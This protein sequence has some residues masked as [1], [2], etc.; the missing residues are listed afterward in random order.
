MFSEIKKQCILFIDFKQAFDNINRNSLVEQMQQMKIPE[1]LIKLT[2]MTMGNS[3]ARISTAEGVT[4]EI[5]IK[6]G[7]RQGDALSSTLINIALDGAIKAAGLDRA[8]TVSAFQVIA[9]ADDLVLIARDKKSLGA[10]LQKLVT[11]T[12]KT[13]ERPTAQPR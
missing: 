2:K 7:V 6:R 1:K 13:K 11:E 5:N 3:R 4:N 9:Y 12:E 10:A 8:I